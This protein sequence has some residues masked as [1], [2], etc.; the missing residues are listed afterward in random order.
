MT[1]HSFKGHPTLAV[2]LAA[3]LG[4]NAP[5]YA[6]TPDARIKELLQAASQ[7]GAGQIQAPNPTMPLTPDGPETMLTLDEAVKLALDKNL[8][9]AVQR[10]NPQLQD[11]A[12]ASARTAFAP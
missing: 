7:Q 4:A 2:A 1:R 11:I 8:D 5:L 6:Q 10:L 9:I 3:T 12:I